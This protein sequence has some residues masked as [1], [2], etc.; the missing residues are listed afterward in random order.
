VNPTND[1]AR[2]SIGQ[3]YVE[4]INAADL[5]ALLAL[6]AEGAVLQHPMGTFTD[7]ESMARFYRDVVFAGQA[8][9]RIAT[10]SRDGNR[11]WVEIEASS[12]LG[13]PGNKVYAADLFELDETGRISRLAIYY[14]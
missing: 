14:R 4:A 10:T 6:F 5:D 11:V 12:P 2:T 13:E 8:V 9:T 7:P 1:A 3:Q